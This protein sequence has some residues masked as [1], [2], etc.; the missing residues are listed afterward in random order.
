[1]INDPIVEEVYRARQ[2]IMDECANDLSKL[3]ERLRAG[4]EK[5]RNRLV[6]PDE[7][8]SRKNGLTPAHRKRRA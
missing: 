1:M 4:E 8:R 2:R 6:T 3:A 7:V 5:N